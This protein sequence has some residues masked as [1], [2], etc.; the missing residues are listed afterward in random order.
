MGTKKNLQQRIRP[1]NIAML[2]CTVFVFLTSC[3]TQK[4]LEYLQ[5]GTDNEQVYDVVQKPD[6]KLR[7]KDELY[8]QISS[9]DEPSSSVFSMAGNEQYVNI[10]TIQ[11]YGASIISYKVDNDGYI[12]LP[13]VGKVLV[14]GKTVEQAADEIEKSVRKILSQ[15]SVSVKLINRY[16]T[17]LGE[18]SRPGQYAYFHDNATIFEACGLAGDITEWGNRKEVTVLRNE[19]GKNIRFTVNL[20]DNASL[21]SEK[22]YLTPNDVIYVKPLKKR[23]WGMSEF[24]YGVILSAITAAILFYSVVE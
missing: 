7:V 21:G 12:L 24:P 8:I 13:V 3:L 20:T 18:V 17:V 22:M 9:L 1:A 19:N 16:V 5:G 11:Q 4:N 14:K 15:P 2:C 23:F 10:A 6:Y